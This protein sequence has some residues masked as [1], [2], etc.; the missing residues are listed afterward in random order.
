MQALDRKLSIAENT[1]E[2]T[3]EEEGGLVDI[4][5]EQD[6]ALLSQSA[7]ADVSTLPSR[8]AAVLSAAS[9]KGAEIGTDAS[10]DKGGGTGRRRS[11]TFAEAPAV[12]AFEDAVQL[13]SPGLRKGFLGKPKP[14][15][16]K[17]S[18][19]T[20]DSS[21]V[22]TLQKAPE[23]LNASGR[24]SRYREQLQSELDEDRKAAFSGK[25]VE[26]PIS[27]QTGAAAGHVVDTAPVRHAVSERHAEGSEQ[28]ARKVS[29]FKQQKQAPHGNF[30]L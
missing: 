4:R 28:S 25:V 18:S 20:D 5:E 3:L 8:S 17:T 6:N 22:S 13:K 10:A 7:P 1:L 9:S 14:A 23:H 29:R 11:V 15:L 19:I 21:S 12:R 27:S 24:T 2:A 30:R 16:R 26:R